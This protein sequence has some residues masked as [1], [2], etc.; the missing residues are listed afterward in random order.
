MGKGLK[1][2][3]YIITF[4]VIISMVSLILM[5]FQLFPKGNWNFVVTAMLSSAYILLVIVLAFRRK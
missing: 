2:L 1:V 4:L 5:Q 3:V